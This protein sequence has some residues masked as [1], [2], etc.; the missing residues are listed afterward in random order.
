MDQLMWQDGSSGAT[1]IA[2]QSQLYS[3]VVSNDCG[4][5]SDE[6]LVT[7]DTQV[8]VVELGADQKLCTGQSL[9]LNADQEFFS[10]YLWSTGSTQPSIVI[11]QPDLYAVTVM[12]DGYEVTDE[13]VIDEDPEC[14]EDGGIYIPNVFSPNGDG[15]NDEWVVSISDVNISGVQCRIFD[16][17]GELMFETKQLPVAWDGTFRNKN[18]NPGVYVSI[19]L[20]QLQNGESEIHSGDITLIR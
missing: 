1:Y 4:N 15:V 9:T 13:V 2:T 10:S 11:T 20:F 18:V 5:V 6:V 17:W 16:R 19:I 3:L 14:H 7:I 12:T 8:P